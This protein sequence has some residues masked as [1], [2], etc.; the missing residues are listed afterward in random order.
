MSDERRGCFLDYFLMP[1]L[2]RAF[3]L[4]Q[5]HQVSDVSGAGDTFVA[6][7]AASLACD[8]DLERAARLANI[9]AGIAVSRPGTAVVGSR[10]L[11][12]EIRRSTL[13]GSGER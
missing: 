4:S 10:D 9:A 12:Q 8:P 5:V 13:T 7:L 1:A 2:Q 11:E 6:A 3:A